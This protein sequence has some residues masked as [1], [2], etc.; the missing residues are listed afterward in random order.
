MRRAAA[1]RTRAARARVRLADGAWT[2]GLLLLNTRALPRLL[3]APHPGTLDGGSPSRPSPLH[4][5]H[6]APADEGGAV[7]QR[8]LRLYERSKL[9]YY[10]AVVTCDSAA[11]ANKVYEECDGMEL[12]KSEPGGRSWLAGVVE[13]R[14]GAERARSIGS[15]WLGR[16]AGSWELL[17]DYTLPTRLTTPPSARPHPC[18]PAA[19]TFD[20]RFVPDEQSFEGRQ[21]R[22]EA[23]DVPAGAMLLQGCSTW[24]APLPCTCRSPCLPAPCRNA[25]PPAPPPPP[26]AQTTRRRRS[27]RARCSTR[28]CS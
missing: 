11:T 24:C 9:R 4:P 3:S 20:L 18:L 10:Y 23:A 22:D 1:T 7:D 28:A 19:C 27:R 16:G 21:V 5:S 8:R 25:P 17:P 12:M 26:A 6:P 2:W 14:G 15:S 13:G